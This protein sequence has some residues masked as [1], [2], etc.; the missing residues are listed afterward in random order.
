MELAPELVDAGLGEGEPEVVAEAVLGLGLV[1]VGVLA[2]VVGRD[3]G[4]RV[5]RVG[6]D[7]VPGHALAEVDVDDRMRPTVMAD[8]DLGVG[9][10]AGEQA[11]Q[12]SRDGRRRGERPGRRVRG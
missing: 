7:P 3:A 6:A 8:R 9:G 12:A 2:E 1:R 4:D 11:A 5:H 10:A